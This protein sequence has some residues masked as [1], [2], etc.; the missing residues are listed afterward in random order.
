MEQSFQIPLQIFWV[1]L[2]QKSPA[3]FTQIRCL[4]KDA[5][6]EFAMSSYAAVSGRSADVCTYKD[7]GYTHGSS[8]R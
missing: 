7:L 3:C 4:A 8:D 1:N 6:I 2:L 5:S